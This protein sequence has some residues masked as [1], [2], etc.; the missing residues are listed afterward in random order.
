MMS[1]GTLAFL[2]ILTFIGGFCIR[3]GP[4]FLGIFILATVTLYVVIRHVRDIQ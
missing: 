2:F 3:N 4:K 1:N